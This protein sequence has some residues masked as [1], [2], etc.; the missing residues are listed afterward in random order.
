MATSTT[1][2]PPSVH[3]YEEDTSRGGRITSWLKGQYALYILI[4][5][6]LV[7]TITEGRSFGA[8]PT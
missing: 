6:L 2:P 4:A 1:A 3:H 5:L 8:A 7:A